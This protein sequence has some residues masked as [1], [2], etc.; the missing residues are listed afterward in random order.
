MW[1]AAEGHLDV[2]D[3]LLEAGADPNRK[4]TSRR[5]T[6]RHNADHPTGGF[7]ALMFA[8]RNGNDAMVRSSGAAAPTST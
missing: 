3:L 1:A 8:R 7:T 4:G 2:V 6:E 5:S